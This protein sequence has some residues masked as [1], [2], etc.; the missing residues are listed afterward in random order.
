MKNYNS[1]IFWHFTGGPDLS[2]LSDD[3]WEDI[4]SPNDLIN[5][6]DLRSEED[7]W[8]ALKGIIESM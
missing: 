6:K 5:L 3:E 8:N 7:A 1:K 2:G 4:I